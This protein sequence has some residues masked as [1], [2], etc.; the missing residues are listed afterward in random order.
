MAATKHVDRRTLPPKG[1]LT[2]NWIPYG[3]LYDPDSSQLIAI[4]EEV[5]DAVLLVFDQYLEGKSLKEIAAALNEAGYTS[6]P[7]RR[8]QLG[9]TNRMKASD[10]DGTIGN[11]PWT[12]VSLKQMFYNPVYCGDWLEEGRI[13]ECPYYYAKEEVPHGQIMPVITENHHP[14]I[15]SR[16]ILTKCCKQYLDTKEKTVSVGGRSSNSSESSI[17]SGNPSSSASYSSSPANT[18]LLFSDLEEDFVIESVL[19]CGECG[20][21]LLKNDV[22]LG[23][24]FHFTAYTCSSFVKLAN[25]KC[26]NR[27]YRQEEFFPAISSLIDKEKKEALKVWEQIGS[28]QKGTQYQRVENFLQRQIDSSVDGVRKNMTLMSRLKTRLSNEKI[29]QEEYDA[30]K[31]RTD[32]ENREY[33]SQ[34]MSALIKVRAFKSACSSDNIWLQTFLSVPDEYDLTQD[35]SFLQN[36]IDRIDLYPD[37]PPVITLSYQEEKKE[38]MDVLYMQLKGRR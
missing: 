30:E 25:S 12:A 28:D 36:M 35:L 24:A 15:V 18:D 3:Y 5:K 19:H 29:T 7:V 10:K 22:N 4:D 37:Q 17:A 11:K 34:V 9:D 31:L 27:F 6:P 33:E 14:A 21:L 32:A 13:W 38:L 16:E 26:T 1:S 8:A 23:P 2:A 20:R